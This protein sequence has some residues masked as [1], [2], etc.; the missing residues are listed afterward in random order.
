METFLCQLQTQPLEIKVLGILELNN[1][2]IPVIISAIMTYL[3]ILIQFG[4]TGGFDVVEEIVKRN[5]TLGGE[6]RGN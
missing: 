4:F 2:L 1:A 3:F 6:Q 5:L